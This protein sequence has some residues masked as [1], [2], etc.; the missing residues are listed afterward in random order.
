M[1]RRIAALEDSGVI[2]DYEGPWGSLQVF[3]PKLY[4]KNCNFI[5][6]FIWI[7]CVSYRSLNIVTRIFK[8]PIPRC[9][10]RKNRRS[11]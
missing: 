2:I 9:T 3:P 10:D 7:L 5:N 11:R 4:Q 6:N 1:N 8:D